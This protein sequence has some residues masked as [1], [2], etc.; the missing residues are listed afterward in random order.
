MSEADTLDGQLEKSYREIYA[1]LGTN[2]A[3]AY[4]DAAR[5]LMSHGFKYR[6]LKLTKEEMNGPLEEG[7]VD[8]P[9]P[10]PAAPESNGNGHQKR[11][12]IPMAFSLGTLLSNARKAARPKISQAHIAHHLQLHQTL[13][14]HYEQGTDVPDWQTVE[15]YLRVCKVTDFGTFKT[16]HL[17]ALTHQV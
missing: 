15:K 1:K 7:Q 10:S 13:I 9:V 11:P 4:L 14:S 6:V 2:A 8:R 16:A 17:S 5:T 12:D 3:Q